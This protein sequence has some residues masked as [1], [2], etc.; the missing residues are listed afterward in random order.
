MSKSLGYTPWIFAF[1]VKP[2]FFS[3]LL[4]PLTHAYQLLGTPGF[5]QCIPSALL[6][7]APSCVTPRQ[8]P[9]NRLEMCSSCRLCTSGNVFMDIMH[10]KHLPPPHL[11]C[12]ARGHGSQGWAAWYSR[13]APWCK[14]VSP[15]KTCPEAKVLEVIH[16]SLKRL[17]GVSPSPSSLAR[18]L[19]TPALPYASSGCGVLEPGSESSFALFELLSLCTS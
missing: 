1:I 4:Q 9:T 7:G 18:Y 13:I 15:T 16:E 8:A 12:P 3:W 17:L 6:Q 2:T 5:T 10:L 19:L 11:A 14:S